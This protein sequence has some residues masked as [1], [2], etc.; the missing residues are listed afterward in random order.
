MEAGLKKVPI[1][2]RHKRTIQIIFALF[3]G[4]LVFFTLFSNTLESLTLP[5]VITEKLVI[6]NIVHTLE[7]SGVLRPIMEAK[8]S[9]PAG[10]K[11]KTI[12][13]EEG[14]HVQKGQKLITF[15][16]KSAERELLDEEAQLDKLKI[17]LQ[18]V[19]DRLKQSTR[20]GEESDSQ[21]TKRELMTGNLD[22]SVQERKVNELRDNL[23]NNKEITAPFDGVITTINA[24]EGL[25]SNGESDVL[26]SNTSQGYWFEF[27]A[28]TSLLS[29]LGISINDKIQVEF[30]VTLNQQTRMSEGS[31]IRIVDA[32]PRTTELAQKLIRVKV[33]DPE[34]EEGTQALVKL[35]KHSQQNGWLISNRAI[36]EDREGKFIYA[37]VEDKGPLGNIFV[38]RKV[39]IQSREIGSKETMIETDGVN[40]ADLIILESSE[41]LQ[42]NNRV[43][44]Q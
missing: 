4:V 16:S 14:E 28:D 1:N 27:L 24:I 19:Q 26:I 23:A 2:R 34:L 38:A 8:L 30:P 29:S 25:T 7:G 41:P 22:L 44:L 15:D 40:G 3:M 33:V 39:R 43:R 35:T 31:I 5:K 17:E 9:N 21:K 37:V 11:V 12:H 42:D 20:E 10:W 18:S 32:E 6:G 13:V 36:H